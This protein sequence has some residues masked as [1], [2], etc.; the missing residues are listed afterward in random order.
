MSNPSEYPVRA[1]P[2][3]YTSELLAVRGLAALVEA[4]PREASTALCRCGVVITGAVDPKSV[5]P[6]LSRQDLP[7]RTDAGRR[8]SSRL[9]ST[10]MLML[11]RW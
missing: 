4:Y 10:H 5:L 1:K 11:T 9:K 3:I 6:E 2:Q 8:L 7:F